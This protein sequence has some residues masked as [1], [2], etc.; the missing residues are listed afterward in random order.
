MVDLVLNG[1][2][3]AFHGPL[4]Y[5]AKIVKIHEPGKDVVETKDGDETMKLEEIPQELHDDKSYYIHYKGWKS[6][7]DEWVPLQRLKA[8][9]VENLKLQKDLKRAALNATSSVS[10]SNGKRSI[11]VSKSSSGGVIAR[12]NK[13]R[14]E[15][16]ME[17]EEEYFR[18]PEIVILIPDSLKS[19]LVDDWEMVTKD[20]QLLK[21]PSNT[22]VDE[23]LTKFRKSLGKKSNIESEILQEFL[24]G[25]KIYFNR[26]LGNILLYRFE[27]QQY[28]D[29]TK[30]PKLKDQ[31]LSHIYGAEHLLRLMVSLPALIAQ[32]TMDQQSVATIKE[33]IEQ[34][35]QFLEKHKKTLFLKC[36]ESVSPGYEALADNV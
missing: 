12:A 13:R 4:L 23:I 16:D 33:H 26:S 31:E 34:L 36:Y 18:K 15:L 11:D 7:W 25:M 19:L 24:S 27:R 8:F 30:D 14:N 22:P 21:L 6:S 28:L 1:K 3:L 9:T 32:T 2:C 5:E 29:L 17:T 10:A 35:L 20:H